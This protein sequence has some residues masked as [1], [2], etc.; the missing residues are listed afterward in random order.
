MT[1]DASF[2]NDGVLKLGAID[3]VKVDSFKTVATDLR[4]RIFVADQANGRIL[5]VSEDGTQVAVIGS[6]GPAEHQFGAEVEGVATDWR[7]N[8]YA[9][10]ELN[11]RFLVFG[12]DGGFL[13]AIA[14]RGLADHQ[15]DHADEFTIDPIRGWLVVADQTGSVP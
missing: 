1:R 8:V 7:G 12:P 4:G 11:E 6:Q 13:R 3:G 9:R 15:R 2:G 10:D 14:D 5:R